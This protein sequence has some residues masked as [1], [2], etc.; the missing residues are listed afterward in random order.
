[1]KLH[2]YHLE[3]YKVLDRGGTI[4]FHLVYGYPGEETDESDITFHGVA[5][6]H[7]INSHGT[8]ITD[9]EEV[10]LESYVLSIEK[11]LSE[12][13]R[14]YGVKYWQSNVTAYIDKLKELDLK[15]WE[16]TS[17]IGFYGFIIAKEVAASA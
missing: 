9:I 7:F 17:A 11:D 1:M 14:M 3:N 13:N 4:E 10:S 12:W 2:D 16:I 8:I 5:L 6:Y 15:V